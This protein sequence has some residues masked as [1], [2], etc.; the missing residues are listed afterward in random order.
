MRLYDIIFFVKNPLRELL[1]QVRTM[2]CLA[3]GTELTSSL[4]TKW[5]EL[6]MKIVKVTVPIK[7]S[8][9]IQAVK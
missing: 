8:E 1:S 5:D 7:L 2:S 6:A 9:R 4:V 3:K